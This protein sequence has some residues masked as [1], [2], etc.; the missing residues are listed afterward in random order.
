MMGDD[1]KDKA[2]GDDISLL[3][4]DL[5]TQL[6]EV[7]AQRTADQ[8]FMERIVQRL[9]ALEQRPSAL[10]SAALVDPQAS[11]FS[12][13]G[14]RKAFQ[15]AANGF[16]AA[17]S[18]PAHASTAFASTTPVSAGSDPRLPLPPPHFLTSQIFPQQTGPPP[19]HH[20]PLTCPPFNPALHHA[21]LTALPTNSQPPTLISQPLNHCLPSPHMPP[22][23]ISRPLLPSHT[24][25]LVPAPALGSHVSTN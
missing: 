22:H 15:P 20:Q 10:P 7:V 14:P 24:S 3:L 5:A 12:F 1:L 16:S 4:K 2:G 17:A 18:T 19:P 23:N 6:K 25:I 13:T 11:V 9:D 8:A 21:S